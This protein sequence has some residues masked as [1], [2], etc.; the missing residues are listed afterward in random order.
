M[1]ESQYTEPSP[2]PR[3]GAENAVN[4]WLRRNV[5]FSFILR[6][7]LAMLAIVFAGLLV[8][9]FFTW[10]A[11]ESG[12]D[13]CYAARNRDITAVKRLLFLGARID[14]K[15]SEG[16]P[17]IIETLLMYAVENGDVEMV[18]TLLEAGANPNQ[19]VGFGYSYQKV[20]NILSEQQFDA[21]SSQLEI[22]HLLLEYGANP[23]WAREFGG[24][25]LEQAISRNNDELVKLLREY[26]AK[27]RVKVPIW[28]M[29]EEVKPEI[30]DSRQDK[31]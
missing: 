12:R 10:R 11:Y 23:N 7:Y 1:P 22:A 4:E 17:P 18:R 30:E 14:G 20:L 29:T 19:P 26:G 3:G 15:V 16:Y 2:K 13:M 28:K 24:T 25:P 21:E 8:S 27:P 9:G 6:H 31:Y 5:F